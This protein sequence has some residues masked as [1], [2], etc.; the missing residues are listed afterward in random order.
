MSDVDPSA[1]LLKEP[2]CCVQEV[3][4]RWLCLQERWR[5]NL[6]DLV[7]LCAGHTRVA[8]VGLRQLCTMICHSRG[9]KHRSITQ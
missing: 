5:D 7:L 9:L 1:C 8:N 4:V 3:M 6:V 2:H